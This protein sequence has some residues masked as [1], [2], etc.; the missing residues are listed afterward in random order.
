ME[1]EKF[2][3]DKSDAE[4]V[5]EQSLKVL[6]KQVVSLMMIKHLKYLRNMA[7]KLREIRFILQKS[8]WR[9]DFPQSWIPLSFI[10][11]TAQSMLW[12]KAARPCVQQ[13]ALLIFWRMES[14]GFL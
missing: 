1:L 14:S 3:F 9:K 8:L 6:R 13:E 2:F 4:F 12:E 7:Q 10:V 11:R 5:H